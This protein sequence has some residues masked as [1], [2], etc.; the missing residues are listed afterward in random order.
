M[1]CKLE[2][3]RALTTCVLQALYGAYTLQLR[4]YNQQKWL[5]AATKVSSETNIL[6]IQARLALLMAF[7]RQIEF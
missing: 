5:G 3:N 6:R 2:S 1:E 4:H 7:C